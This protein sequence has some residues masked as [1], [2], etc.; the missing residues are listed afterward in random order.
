M[1][2]H[3]VPG[4]QKLSKIKTAF[5]W[6]SALLAPHHGF[7]QAQR[8]AAQDTGSEVRLA[9]RQIHVSGATLVPGG[10][11]D[12]AVEPFVG[13]DKSLGDL[14]AAKQAVQ[15]V[16]DRAGYKLVAIGLPEQI[17]LDGDVTLTV[18]EIPVG[19]VKVSGNQHFK[20]DSIR[21]ALPA[22]QEAQPLDFNRLD[23][24]L[25][26]ANE[27]SAR[28]LSLEFNE[29]REGTAD[30]N[31]KVTEQKP[32]KFGATL[33]NT[34]S[35][36]T[37]VTRLGL[38][39]SDSDLFGLGHTGTFAY[40]TSPEKID[41]VTQF[42]A[43]YQVPL[44]R[45]GG[46]LDVNASYSD[47]DSGRVADAFNV[48]GKGTTTGVH[49]VQSLVRTASVHHS[50]DFGL[51]YKRFKNTLDFGGTNLGVDVNALPA[52]IGYRFDGAMPGQGHLDGSA[53]YVRNVP[54]GALNNDTTYNASRAGARANWQAVRLNATYTQPFLKDWQ[55][56]VRLEHQYTNE[57]LISG[58]QFGLGGIRS[59]RGFSER[60][61]TGDRGTRYNF[62]LYTPQVAEGHR[63][64]GFVDGGYLRRVNAQPGEV[65]SLFVQT[66]GLGWRWTMNKGPSVS[67]DWAYV[68]KGTS[69]RPHGSQ[70]LHFAAS[71]W[72]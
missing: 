29:G 64:V 1:L 50:L 69:S 27:N 30:I 47:V 19:Q 70:M 16:Y 11:L 61:I 52:S 56:V 42:G 32:L 4:E 15:Q 72:I 36:A 8:V 45:L 12:E 18:K 17:G 23:K 26:L 7:A 2:Q 62:E 35:R 22:L 31:V 51:D 39:V 67:L 43:F 6:G 44:P 34:G 25:Y 54:A 13:E 21:A 9:I 58:E 57:P 38:L 53:T 40:T 33:D 55:A 3:K 48:A 24:Q 41:K 49:Y 5:L 59:V 65:V 68:G 37:G 66:Y 46:K 63:F 28:N 71:W 20:A 60:E 14:L 10:V